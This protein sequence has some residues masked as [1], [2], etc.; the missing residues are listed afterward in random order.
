MKVLSLLLLFSNLLLLLILRPRPLLP[1]PLL[2]LQP[3]LHPRQIMR[4]ITI[5][6]KT[7]HDLESVVVEVVEA[8]QLAVSV[9]LLPSE[10]EVPDLCQKCPSVVW[11]C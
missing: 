8:G 11:I 3:K 10:A 9:C 5:L 2:Q 6:I 7:Q 4:V 1:Q